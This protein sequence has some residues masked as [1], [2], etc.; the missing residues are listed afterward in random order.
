[1]MKILQAFDFL[2]LPHGG[3][4]VDIVYKLSKALVQRGHE[5]TICTGDYELDYK[6][7]SGL[8]DVGLKI[9]HSYINKHGVYLM[10][11]L[12]E[13]EIQ[14]YDLI[15][16]HC[17]RSI[18]NVMLVQKANLHGVP[19][20][21]DAHGSTVVHTGCK[22][23]LLDMFDLWFGTSIVDRAK[24]VIAETETGINEWKRLGVDNS[25]I[26]LQHP[27]LDTGEFAVLPD[28][29]TFRKKYRIGDEFMVLFLGRLHP[30]KGIDI[31]ID[32]IQILQEQDIH[33]K[34]VIAGHDDGAMES[35]VNRIEMYP[36]DWK[37]DVL[38]TGFIS[39]AEKMSALVDADVLVQPSRNEAGAR[40]SLEA[41]MAGTPVVVSRDTGAGQEIAKMDGGLLFENGDASSLAHAIRC[42]MDDLEATR[43]RTGKARE[44]IGMNL[45]LDR[46]V[47]QYEK[48]YREA[49]LQ[50]NGYM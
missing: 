24:F 26:R 46:Q 16:M 36:V 20:I 14:D 9:Y 28:K 23:L 30:A 21:I 10:P 25:K 45:S 7:L 33:C 17:Y 13:L 39:G 47:E 38:F 18:Q 19:Y 4:T 32:A 41:I 34:L 37:P 29:G 1:M 40:P 48:L 43:V 22:K 27:L 49:V 42:T 12:S 44:Y 6:Y 8:K 11:G 5:V 3:G 31:L 2:S 35:L 50:Q 15:H